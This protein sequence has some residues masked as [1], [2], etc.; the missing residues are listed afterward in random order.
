MGF[1][2]AGRV[3]QRIE[4][5]DHSLDHLDGCLAF[6]MKGTARARHGVS[7]PAFGSR[8]GMTMKSV[9]TTL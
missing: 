3:G 4:Q 8:K 9:Y 2:V 1:A 6:F 5:R 7:G